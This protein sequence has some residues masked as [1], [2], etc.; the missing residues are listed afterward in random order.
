MDRRENTS[1]AKVRRMLQHESCHAFVLARARRTWGDVSGAHEAVQRRINANSAR[2]TIATDS[3]SSLQRQ[4][5]QTFGHR[6]AL[7]AEHPNVAHN[8]LRRARH[9]RDT[10]R[11]LA[12]WVKVLWFSS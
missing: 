4:S 7:S 1:F 9:T 11:T 2:S 12:T 10:G 3:V 5:R 8:L 6:V